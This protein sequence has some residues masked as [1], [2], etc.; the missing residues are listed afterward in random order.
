MS[1]LVIQLIRLGY[2]LSKPFALCR[3][4]I[5]ACIIIIC[6]DSFSGVLSVITCYCCQTLNKYY[7]NST[8]K[9]V[10][11]LIT[12]LQVESRVW[13][14]ITWRY[15]SMDR[16]LGALKGLIQQTV[17]YNLSIPSAFLVCRKHIPGTNI[18]WYHT[19]LGITSLCAVYHTGTRNIYAGPA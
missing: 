14:Q 17:S 8:T 19:Q 1:Y 18:D 13:G 3:M 7:G 15:C 11:L 2:S 12:P 4:Y 9:Y 5:S 16:G 6:D 10:G